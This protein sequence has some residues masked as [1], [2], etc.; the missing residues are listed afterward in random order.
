MDRC[1]DPMAVGWFMS[2]LLQFGA[3]GHSNLTK[4]ICKLMRMKVYCVGELILR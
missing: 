2:F 3:S 4:D 1:A